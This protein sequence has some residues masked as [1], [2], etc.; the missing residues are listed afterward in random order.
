MTTQSLR[1]GLRSTMSNDLIQ[2]LQN[3]GRPRVLVFE[4][5]ELP[6]SEPGRDPV[7]GHLRAQGYDLVALAGP[8]V[9]MQA[10]EFPEFAP[11]NGRT[12]HAR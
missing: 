1:N 12:P 11:L 6:K 9:V 8:S 2:V 7:V 5:H 10:A 3:L 4:R